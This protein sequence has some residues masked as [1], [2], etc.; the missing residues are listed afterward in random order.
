MK[1][2]ERMQPMITATDQTHAN[3]MLLLQAMRSL[4]RIKLDHLRRRQA[5]GVIVATR[6]IRKIADEVE[7][8]LAHIAAKNGS[9]Q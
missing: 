4:D 2:D 1:P 7:A 8:E 3:L 6:V 5:V 9:P